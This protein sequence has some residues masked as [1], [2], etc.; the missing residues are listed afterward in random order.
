MMTTAR[1]ISDAITRPR[2][3]RAS[4]SSVR[5]RRSIQGLAGRRNDAE[6]PADVLLGLKPGDAVIAP[7]GLPDRRRP[8][9][10]ADHPDGGGADSGHDD[11]RGQRQLDQGERLPWR[12]ADAA[13]RHLDRRLDAGERGDRVA[14][15]RQH[16]IERQREQ[17]RQKA[18]SAET[19][20]EVGGGEMRKSQ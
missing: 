10:R 4:P 12:H 3:R 9:R 13:R 15:D 8:R 17:G 1:P 11:R 20:A 19:E 16:R 6:Q 5:A 18:Q 2:E 14:Q 7:S